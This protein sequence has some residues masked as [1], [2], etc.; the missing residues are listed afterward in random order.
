M[1]KNVVVVI[2]TCKRVSCQVEK[3]AYEVS[4]TGKK[5]EEQ[6]DK[7]LTKPIR[8]RH[9]EFVEVKTTN[10]ATKHKSQSKNLFSVLLTA[11][12]RTFRTVCVS[13]HVSAV[14]KRSCVTA[15]GLQ[16]SQL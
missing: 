15:G 10:T 16:V 11:L 12:D 6:R 2:S 5:T 3:V 7:T 4:R 9:F 13:H 8:I 1:A 14:H